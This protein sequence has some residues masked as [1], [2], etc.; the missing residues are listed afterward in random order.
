MDPILAQNNEYFNKTLLTKKNAKLS[1]LIALPEPFPTVL[2]LIYGGIAL[3]A[4]VTN[5][6][7]VIVLVKK[8]KT[9]SDLR[10]YLINL[11]AADLSMAIFSVPFN[12]SDVMYGYWRFPLFMCPFSRFMTIC[13]I[14]NSIFTLTAIGIERYRK[15]ILLFH[16][17]K[18]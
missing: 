4:F 5:I 8:M 10:I 12:Y 9:S 1:D 14:S 11:A 16:L 6:S 15:F 17:F 7:A 18:L 13:T 3:I 2:A